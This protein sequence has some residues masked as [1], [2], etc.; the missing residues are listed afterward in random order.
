MQHG[1]PSI[2]S[3]PDETIQMPAPGASEQLDS[4]TSSSFGSGSISYKVESNC[5]NLSEVT[6]PAEL[7]EALE[8]SVMH[9]GDLSTAQ[10]LGVLGKGGMS[11]VYH[12][13]YKHR[14]L[15][16]KV[17]QPQ[18]R[19]DRGITSLVLESI[20]CDKAHNIGERAPA[21]RM[22]DPQHACFAMSTL[23]DHSLKRELP[24]LET[25][26]DQFALGVEVLEAAIGA[27]DSSV[28]HNDIKPANLLRT[29]TG[30]LVLSDFGL[31]KA[32]GQSLS[33][34]G[35]G[36]TPAYMAPEQVLQ[37]ND[38]ASSDTDTFATALVLAEILDE[39][40][41]NMGEFL[42]I[43]LAIKLMARLT[44]VQE[45][46]RYIDHVA[47]QCGSQK[48]AIRTLLGDAILSP[49]GNRTRQNDVLTE[50][51]RIGEKLV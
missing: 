3:E 21:I 49:L 2:A 12:V 33:D 22:V 24:K 7:T 50:W 51:K 16:L 15:A 35:G 6:V 5:M 1:P 11:T 29:Q 19:D 27:K 38:E 13:R 36:G 28:V 45:H 43:A 42:D 47:A 32:A 30:R 26:H 34:S 46:A 17:L 40:H 18:C 23:C 10:V 44:D 8:N 14:Y 39:T 25:A 37:S 31:A 48:K 41:K 9:V 20:H 4:G